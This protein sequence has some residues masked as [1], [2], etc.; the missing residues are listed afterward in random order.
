[1]RLG[2]IVIDSLDEHLHQLG[3]DYPERFRRLFG[4]AGAEI[5]CFEGRTAP[6]PDPST[7][8]G[9]I[10]PGSRQSV[11]DDLPWIEALEAWALQVMAAD[12]PLIG[13][14]FGHQLIA[15]ALGASVA[16][17]DGGW[18]IGAI[19][20]AVAPEA[21]ELGWLDGRMGGGFRLLA[22][23]QDQVLELPDGARLLASAPTCPIAA[24]SI[25]ER[26]LCVQ[27]HP[28]F[29]PGVVAPLYEGRRERVGTEVVDAALA[30]LDRPLDNE[31]VARLLTSVVAPG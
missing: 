31:R 2:L 6:L 27:G 26:V 28:E 7:C 23:H 25:G 14:C 13:V 30:T 1:M 4:A 22:S 17:A 5:E 18:N 15:R 12:I 21:E 19:D 11:Y 3:G 10:I 20:Y 24:Y 16:K 29:D 8:D 9:W